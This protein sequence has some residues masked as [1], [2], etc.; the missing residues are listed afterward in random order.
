MQ[1]NNVS[2]IPFLRLWG[3]DISP[4]Y[5]SFYEVNSTER[6]IIKKEGCVR[7]RGN[8]INMAFSFEYAM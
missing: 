4:S 3:F 2:H 1:F 6:L 7:I 5:A 8:L